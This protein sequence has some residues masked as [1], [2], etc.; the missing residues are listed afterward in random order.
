M[1][2]PTTYPVGTKYRAKGKYWAR[3]YHTGVDY[4]APTGSKVKAPDDSEILHA[5]RG[6]WGEAYGIHVVGRCEVDGIAYEW[7]VAH[8]SR[9]EVKAGQRVTNGTLLGL[10]GATGNVT[11]PHVHFEVRKSP[12]RY[13]N[14][15]NP[16][17]VSGAPVVHTRKA[18]GRRF[19]HYTK[20]GYRA[21]NSY[22][23]LRR[24]RKEH[25][26]WV[27]L[28]WQ[29]SGDKAPKP[30]NTHWG[31]PKTEKWTLRGKPITTAFKHLPWSTIK[32]LRTADGYK[33]H[34]P[35]EMFRKAKAL[36]LR[37]EFE[38]K[39]DARW[40]DP[41]IWERIARVARIVWGDA[42]KSHVEVKTLSNLTGGQTAALR[43]LAA[44]ESV[45]FTTILLARGTAKTKVFNTD[46]VTYVRGSTRKYPS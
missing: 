23:G 29:L 40:E 6:G 38:A 15:V 35:I 18:P 3:G 4:L 31:T 21:T 28:D 25:Y 37:I 22:K 33:I 41:A 39:G 5:G 19:A 30:I 20:P 12:F 7:I 16:T 45:G 36:G 46:A 42:W 26:G 9:V 34:T 2:A 43:R 14:D 32:Q 44:A 8:L 10:S 11:G 1:T 24:A 17:I 13:G 27:D